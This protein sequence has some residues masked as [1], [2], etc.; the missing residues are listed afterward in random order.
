MAP[1][2]L[3]P[4]SESPAPATDTKLNP[5]IPVV[6]LQLH[7][8]QQQLKED[9]E[10]Q[11]AHLRQLPDAD[12]VQH[13]FPARKNL[14]PHL[15]TL[16]P[17]PYQ[18]SDLLKHENRDE[19]I[20]QLAHLISRRGVVFFKSQ[21]ISTDS[22]KELVRLLGDLTGRPSQHGL[23]VHPF[24]TADA[25]GGLGDQVQVITSE[26]RE[27]YAK[28]PILSLRS[29]LGRSL[30]HSDVSFEKAPSDYAFLRIHTLP[31]TGGDTLWAS[32]Y[33]LYDRLT[34]AFRHLL[35][36]LTATHRADYFN[37]L[38]QRT[39]KPV[40]T[41][42]GSPLNVSTHLEATHPCIRTHPLTKW[43]SLYLNPDFTTKINELSNDESAVI[44]EHVY[45]LLTENH[46]L[47]VRFTWEKD[48]VALWDNR[49]TL[50]TPTYDY[51]DEEIRLGERS[52]GVGEVPEF[53]AQGKSRRDGLGVP[54]PMLIRPYVEGWRKEG[55]AK[56]AETAATA[57]VM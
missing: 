16:F 38:A 42:R 22:Q 56:A 43:N 9:I 48:D 5:T 44:L 25:K 6:P 1:T 41:P 40:K 35:E 7:Q 39:G 37:T 24:F 31:E 17:A 36:P 27:L 4:P 53:D 13:I 23:H 14:T 46:D 20:A 19:L 34:P 2:T 18:L 32:G 47:Q 57:P 10:S 11:N 29:E 8:Q 50:H 54:A 33:E 28:D 45:K 26:F 3:Q 12:L 51:G 30:W 49:C 21:N 15:G 55:A 52:L